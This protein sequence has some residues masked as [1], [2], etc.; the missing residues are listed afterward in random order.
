MGTCQKMRDELF[1]RY[2][3]ENVIFSTDLS[4]FSFERSENKPRDA[5]LPARI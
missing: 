2:P 1:E 5:E 3:N 4:Q